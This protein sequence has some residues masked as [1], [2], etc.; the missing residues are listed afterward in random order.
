MMTGRS[1]SARS[2]LVLAS[3]AESLKLFQVLLLLVSI[4]RPADGQS[5]GWAK[6]AGGGDWDYA[7]AAAVDHDGNVYITGPF[8]RQCGCGNQI[9]FDPGGPNQTT[10]PGVWRSDVFV[11]KYDTTGALLW[12]RSASTADFEESFGIAV[13]A[14]GN[15]YVA[16]V[17][18]SVGPLVMKFDRNGND[19]WTRVLPSVGG[20][21]PFAIAVGAEGS[22]YVT[23]YAPDPQ[24]GGSVITVWRLDASGNPMWTRQATGLHYG[25]GAGISVDSAGNA[26]VT[27]LLNAGTATF[28]TGEP[29][30]TTLGDVNG[31]ANEMFIAKYD[32][33]GSLMWAKQ[34]ADIAGYLAYG[35][36]IRVDSAG[37]PH[38][39]MLGNTILGLGEPTETPISGSILAKYSTTGQFLWATSVSQQNSEPRAL[40]VGDVGHTFVTGYIAGAL[41]IAKYDANGNLLW[42][43]Q[44]VSVDPMTR[45]GD[46]GYGV[47][48]DSAGNAYVAGG[49]AG[50]TMFGP[51]EPSETILSSSS[52][53]DVDLLLAKYSADNAV[54]TVTLEATDAAA[55]ETGSDPGFFT[56]T[57]TGVT[58]ASLDVLY[59]VGGSA[60]NGT[61]FTPTLSG[62]VTIPGGQVTATITITPVDDSDGESDETVSLTLSTNAT[63]S[64]GTPAAASVTIVDDDVPTVALEATDAAASETGPDPGLFTVT[65]TGVTTASLDVLYTVGGSAID[66]T[67][68]TPTLTGTVIIPPGQ[69]IAIITI[70]PVDDP[71]VE[72]DETV[73]LMISSNAAYN[74]GTPGVASV[75]IADN[76]VPTVTL[77]A[78]DAAASEA[79][80]SPGTITVTRSGDTSAALAISVLRS[81]TASVSDYTGAG[82]GAAFTVT[83]PARQAAVS[84]T[85]TPLQDNVVEGPETVV[86]TLAPA[87]GYIVGAANAATVTIFDDPP[88]VNILASDAEA[89][90]TGP[91][92][93]TFAVTRVLDALIEGDETVA[94]T[95]TSSVNYTIGPASS[96]LLTIHDAERGN[97]FY[98]FHNYSN[99]ADVDSYS[100]TDGGFI[101]NIRFSPRADFGHFAYGDGFFWLYRRFSNRSEVD[102]YSASTGQFAQTIRL[103]PHTDFGHFA[104]G[105]GA[106]WLYRSFSNRSEVD[107]YSAS[108]GQFIQTIRLSP[109]T[110]FG[111]FAYGDG[112]LWLYRSFSNRSEV[113]KYSANTG[114]FIQTIRL[115]PH[116]GFGDFAYGDG[117]FWLYRRFSNRSEVDKYSASTGQFVQNIRF[118]MQTDGGQF[119]YGEGF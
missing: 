75:V 47:A 44:P 69:A 30:E 95:L 92:V 114:Q 98:V 89:S 109:H 22:S 80:P 39:T 54:P 116:T 63:Y 117:F 29:N 15:S 19:V 112:F 73:S 62:T 67:D 49:F 53:L 13:D 21:Y 32:G 104:Y 8:N 34:S 76:D 45:G 7:T 72:G 101:Q 82:G 51:G 70:T 9:T 86:L 56:V 55:S 17:Q 96:A 91:D 12:A 97:R 61:D 99:R 38:I 107:K 115:S 84:I 35:L 41:F 14:A 42:M 71:D 102:K 88:V 77:E 1:V 6:Q 26:Y 111:H 68:F 100:A 119:A 18:L 78:T 94:L 27:G 103:S 110:G 59:T 83:I 16:L 106:F 52:I 105:D 90:E 10:L 64:V 40:A 108:T 5:L 74:V 28:G 85:I 66:G 118:S 23:G 2:V 36:A 46:A 24:A 65:R 20:G 93:G 60:I 79:G 3:R 50:T 58:T 48:L 113:D 57:R 43:R 37:N 25:G 4:V 81:G 31:A 33:S 11:A 87:P